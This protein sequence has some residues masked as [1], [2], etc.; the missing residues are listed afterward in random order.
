M[1][2]QI[3][4]A[5]LLLA[6]CATPVGPEA[7]QA[8]SYADHLIGRL[9]NLRQDHEAAADRYFAA[10]QREPRNPALL[11]G[12]VVAS[13]AS[14]DV[15]RA[16]QAAR[17]APR[18]EAPA[19]VHLVRAADDL[20]AGRTRAAA[21]ELNRSQ[22]SA[23]EGLV[24]RMMLVWARAADG[25]VDDVIVDLAPLASI[26]PYGG[27]FAYQQAMALDFAGRNEEA[28]STYAAAA[29]GGMFLPPAIERHADLLA[30]TGRAS[31]AGALLS[32]AANGSNPA[33]AAAHARLSAG[34]PIA[35]RRIGAAD[36]AAVGLYGLA[37]IFQQEGDATNA[38]ATLTLALMLDP[39]LD[40]ARLT[41]AQVQTDLGH[42]D[43]ARAAL[44]PIPASSPYA[45]T[46]QMMQAWSLID[47]GRDE[48]A[49]TA[50][51]AAADHGDA[52]AKR[53]LADMYGN[54]RRFG[55]AEPLYTELIAASPD[56]WTLYFARGASRERLGR[57]AEAETDFRRALELAPDQPEVMNYLGYTWIDR[58]EHLQ[59]GLAMIQRAVEL[60]PQSGAIVDSLGWAYYRLGDYAQALDHLERA[61]ELAPADP[62]LNDHLGDV[63]WRVGRRIEARF[64]WQRT[65]T[66]NPDNPELIQ[67]KLD[68]GLP[69]QPAP[70]SANR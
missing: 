28:L 41:F 12:A 43:R 25:H 35:E 23:A 26:R 36:G 10:L 3:T 66:L 63:Y 7:Q 19:Y 47:E 51:R 37:A 15:A 8:E 57:W 31:E 40:A 58:G 67:A 49:L 38:L 27:L 44:A 21:E 68:H 50:A 64:Q 56:D 32:D 4:A 34:A 30:R 18:V 54:L 48:E 60:R 29:D 6:A 55:E 2:L 53:T 45:T 62:T 42:A 69:E 1:R 61:V 13:L 33:L 9:A 24:S 46:A 39:Q 52:R 17:L 65:L 11:E 20:A 70:R 59:E 22:G 14:G 16:R 5:C